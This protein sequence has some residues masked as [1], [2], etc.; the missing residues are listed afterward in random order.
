VEGR[1]EWLD[2]VK[3]RRGERKDNSPED[4]EMKREVSTAQMRITGARSEH[5][6]STPVAR[7]EAPRARESRERARERG[8]NVPTLGSGGERFFKNTLWAHQTGTIDCLMHTGQRT[9]ERG[10]A[11]AWPVHQTVHSAVSGAHRTVR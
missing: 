7:W 11:R 9:A 3:R 10:C 2:R 8:G 6:R 1:G 4:E 5:G